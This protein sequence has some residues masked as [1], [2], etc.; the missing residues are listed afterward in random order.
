VADWVGEE[1][2]RC[3][4]VP[5]GCLGVWRGF[6]LHRV[7]GA[8]GRDCVPKDDSDSSYD[9]SDSSYDD[10]D[11]SY[12][13]SDSSYDDGGSYDGYDIAPGPRHCQ[14]RRKHDNA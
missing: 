6:G 4:S 10:S 7:G 13:D 14:H 1:L 11:S 9:D 8:A 2:Q 3:S 5:L 12:D